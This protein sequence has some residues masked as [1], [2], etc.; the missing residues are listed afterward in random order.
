MR[1]HF[2]REPAILVSLAICAAAIVLTVAN[3]TPVHAIA[4]V[5][6]VLV[7]PWAAASRLA[8]I[9][10]SDVTGGRL[11]AS[12]GLG[13]ASIVLLG[14]LLAVTWGLTEHAVAVGALLL[15]VGLTVAGSQP[16]E[17][18]PPRRRWSPLGM[19]LIVGAALIVGVAFEIARQA[20]LDSAQ[21]ET[22]Y[23]A[24]ALQDG[25]HLKLGLRNA[26]DRPAQFTVRIAAGDAVH[27]DVVTVPRNELRLIPGPVRNLKRPLKIRVTVSV[28]GRLRG[29]VMRLSTS[30]LN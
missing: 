7:L 11:A 16:D 18:R 24:F 12:G 6:L 22:S 21:R 29:P 4:G 30:P 5:A 15:V 23:A 13:L 2:G 25:G 17:P 26:T 3:R 28:D 1:A 19:T 9:R 27:K 10:R 8:V 20:A 14:L